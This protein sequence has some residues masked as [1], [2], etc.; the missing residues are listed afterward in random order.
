MELYERIEK[1]VS[2]MILHVV[3]VQSFGREGCLELHCDRGKLSLLLAKD[4]DVPP[5]GSEE[6]PPA[7]GSTY[8]PAAHV[9]LGGPS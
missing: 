6:R 5:E 2:K 9:D 4:N 8:V 1:L 3:L 7:S